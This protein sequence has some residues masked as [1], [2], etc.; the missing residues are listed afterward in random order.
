MVKNSIKITENE[1]CKIIKESVNKILNEG[2]DYIQKVNLLID[3]ANNAYMEAAQVQDGDNYPLMDKNGNNYGLKSKIILDKQGYV[4]I[5]FIDNSN[6]W[7]DYSNTEKIRVLKKVNGK[8]QI[9]KGDY[10]EEGWLDVQKKLKRIIRDAQI[11]IEY[12]K[13][14]DPSWE[15]A[16]SSEEYNS[17]RSNLKDMNK[18]IGRK[19]NTGIEYL[20]K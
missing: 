13:N 12:F 10:F 9:I 7:G 6:G 2:I 1:L 18:K 14:Y 17:N 5:P 3:A 20:N 16:E 8:I 4:I 11:G 15:E 19:A